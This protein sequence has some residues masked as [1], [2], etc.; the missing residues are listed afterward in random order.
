MKT[1][2][3]DGRIVVKLEATDEDKQPDTRLAIEAR[4][5]VSSGPATADNDKKRELRFVQRET[6]GEYVA[7]IKAEEAGTYFITARVKRKV[8][9]GNTEVEEV[10]VVRAAE[11]LPLAPEFSVVPTNTPLMKRLADMTGGK[12]FPDDEEALAKVAKD[13]TL[14]REFK[15]PVLAKLPLWFWLVFVAGYVLLADITARRLAVDTSKLSKWWT[16]SW[17]RLRGQI[18]PEP[19]REV[20]TA[21]LA[22]RR[23][24]V[25]GDAARAAR[26]FEAPLL[27]TGPVPTA[28]TAPPPGQAPP[29]A[30][31]PKPPEAETG[32]VFGRL[33]KA[34][35]KIMDERKKDR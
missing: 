30:E 27:P 2:V 9:R 35:K 26:R 23:P 15:K 8:K 17:L 13:R 25:G 14:F 1:E 32:D 7:E 21:R 33:A 18:I 22:P 34:K 3:I 24:V 20:V 28:G 4:Y 19:E 6:A 10:E 11:T 12:I 5:S 31:Q 29:A 16:R